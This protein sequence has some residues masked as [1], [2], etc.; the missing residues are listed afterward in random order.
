VAKEIAAAGRLPF[1]RARFLSLKSDLGDRAKLP[2]GFVRDCSRTLLGRGDAVFETAK[3]AFRRWRMFDMGWVRVANPE[4]KITHGQV[5]A[6]EV[7]A[8]GLWS[9][10]LS[11]IVETVDFPSRFGFIYSATSAHVEEGEECFLLE[12]DRETDE[13]WYELEAVSRPRALM[14]RIG[15]PVTWHFQHRFARDS[16]RRMREEVER[17]KSRSFDSPPPSSTPQ[18]KTCLRGPGN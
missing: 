14:A 12:H 9:I 16:H 7:K 1:A 17:G 10:N 6:V 15:L 8:L 3:E 13:V 18:T 5:V 11:Q 2:F 4:A